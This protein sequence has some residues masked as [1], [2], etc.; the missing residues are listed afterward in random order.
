MREFLCKGKKNCWGCSLQID[1]SQ[2]V[3]PKKCIFTGCSQEW[4]EVF[5]LIRVPIENG[6]ALLFQT[7]EDAE[8]EDE[9]CRH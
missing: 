8:A 3:E 4:E 7:E 9:S 1:S 2:K 5:E 6:R